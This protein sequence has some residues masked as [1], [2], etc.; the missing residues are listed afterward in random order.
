VQTLI[1]KEEGREMSLED[2]ER[3]IRVLEDIETIKKL[4]ARYC[5]LCDEHF[6]ADGLA[7]LFTE[8]AV[9]DRGALGC[10]RGRKAIQTFFGRP[11]RRYF[12]FLCTKS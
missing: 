7:V 11:P 12:P 4:K 5:A 6:D 9:W 3:R 2:L 10:Y 1:K 8:D